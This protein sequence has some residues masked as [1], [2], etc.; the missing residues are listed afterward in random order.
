MSKKK[1]DIKD[2][3]NKAKS[4]EKYIAPIPKVEEKLDKKSSSKMGRPSEK[5]PGIEYVKLSARIPFDTRKRLRLAL[6]DR[7][8]DKFKTQDEMIN[9]ALLYFLDNYKP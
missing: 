5:K 4:K 1:T 3:L 9:A 2:L 8:A 6:A 7:F